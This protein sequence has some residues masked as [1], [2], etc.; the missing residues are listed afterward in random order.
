MQSEKS[1]IENYIKLHNIESCLDVVINEVIEKRPSN[2]FK[3]ISTLLET[4]SLSEILDI[5]LSYTL[6]ENNNLGINCIIRTNL[7]IYTSNI[8]LPFLLQQQILNSNSSNPSILNIENEEDKI[9]QLLKGQDPRNLKHIERLI[10]ECY[11]TSD[12]G[13]N[14]EKD[15]IVK[16][17]RLILTMC[18]FRAAAAHKCEPLY[19]FI[20]SYYEINCT[21]SPNSDILKVPQPSI[22]ITNGVTPNLPNISFQTLNIT[23]SPKISSE[24]ANDDEL[25]GILNIESSLLYIKRLLSR[26][27]AKLDVEK[28]ITVLTSKCATTTYTLPVA[29]LGGDVAGGKATAEKSVGIVVATLVKAPA[30]DVS[31]VYQR[32]GRFV[33]ARNREEQLRRRRGL[34]KNRSGGEGVAGC[35][36]LR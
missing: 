4:K 32:A 16:A 29:T 5:K 34:V 24:I 26:F 1:K 17:L 21:I 35:G 25:S 19:K 23:P 33:A 27:Q 10:V 28:T 13:T 3:V 31:A 36:G 7:G 12:S 20:S 22:S 8:G 18:C 11:V 9:N 6:C 2:P 14:K 30:R 15:S